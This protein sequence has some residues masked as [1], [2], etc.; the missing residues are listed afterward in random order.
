VSKSHPKEVSKS[1]PQAIIDALIDGDMKVLEQYVSKDNV[2]LVDERGYTLLSRAATAGDL[3][4]KV[5]R[6]LIKRG[7]DV[8]VR[9]REG[10]TLLHSAAH[11][12]QKDLALV[13]LSAGCDPNAVDSAGQTALVKVLMALNPKKELIKLLIKYRADPDAKGEGSESAKEIAAQ[14]GQMD[15]F[16]ARWGSN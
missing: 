1:H 4:M 5:V 9:L 11:L 12:L 7:A 3:N 2:N 15:L 10:W 13:L 14:M 8:N 16:P 6:L